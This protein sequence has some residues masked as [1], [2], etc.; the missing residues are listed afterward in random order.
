MKRVIQISI[1]ISLLGGVVLAQVQIS[2]GETPSSSGRH[3][4]RAIPTEQLH[5]VFVEATSPTGYCIQWGRS[6]DGGDNWVIR[7]IPDPSPF[8]Q[9]PSVGLPWYYSGQPC[10]VCVS[11]GTS[12][13]PS[14]CAYRWFD[15]SNWNGFDIP[16]EGPVHKTSLT[17]FQDEV[18]WTWE[19]WLANS[20]GW[21]GI[22]YAYCKYTGER[23]QTGLLTGYNCQSPSIAVDG[24]GNAYISHCDGN[25]RIT[26]WRK[27]SGQSNW[28][29]CRGPAPHTPGKYQIQT[30]CECFGDS[31]FVGWCEEDPNA[32]DPRATRDVFRMSAYLNDWPLW[33]D[34]KLPF[35]PTPNRISESPTIAEGEFLVLAEQEPMSG[36]LDLYYYSRRFGQ[37]WLLPSPTPYESNYPS[38]LMREKFDVRLYCPWTEVDPYQV[39]F[40]RKHF[41]LPPKAEQE[42]VY[43]TVDIGKEKPSHY[44]LKRDGFKVYNQYAIDYAKDFLSYNLHYLDPRYGYILK[45]SAYFEGIQPVKADL[46]IDGESFGS[47]QIMPNALK[48]FSIIIPSRLYQRDSRIIVVL[49][50]KEGEFVPL[51]DLTVYQFEPEIKG[52]GGIQTAGLTNAKTRDIITV[53]PNPLCRKTTVKFEIRNPESE[54]TLRI[55][56][57]TGRLVRQFDHKT[58]RHSDQLTWNCTDDRGNTVS[59]GVYLLRAEIGNKVFTKKM[60]IVK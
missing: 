25:N 32:P 58:I 10:T 31:I 4:A 2:P 1:A 11:Y 42:R 18:F 57:A 44:C 28:A 21:A 36:Q 49:K 39:W 37:G 33:W 22:H 17:T 27:P 7:P 45:G 19:E 29:S 54:I 43:Y 40:Y 20:K 30:F 23:L 47:L 9:D 8:L 53:S 12:E 60:V 46:T 14:R 26:V 52:E 56:D 13:W 48:T 51:A 38:V 5:L 55:F 15:G 24:D 35:N 34:N 16:S 41:N 50:N 3:L 6:P 59:P